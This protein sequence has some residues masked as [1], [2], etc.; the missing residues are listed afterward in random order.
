M[1]FLNKHYPAQSFSKH[2][3]KVMILENQIIN[4]Y[5]VFLSK[6]IE[7][8]KSEVEAF[9]AA[10]KIDQLDS[11]SRPKSNYLNPTFR[12]FSC[13]LPKTLVGKIKSMILNGLAGGFD[14]VV[15]PL[16]AWV[17]KVEADYG[18]LPFVPADYDMKGKSKGSSVKTRRSFPQKVD[19]M[20]NAMYKR[21]DQLEEEFDSL[22]DQP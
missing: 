18:E 8:L 3:R 1:N 4:Q 15:E 2:K 13:Y 5:R 7:N 11:N 14:D 22:D 9:K 17:R 12:Q 21:I 20:L 6:Q 16:W 10:H 19:T